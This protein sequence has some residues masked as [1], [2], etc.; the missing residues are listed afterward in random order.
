VGDADVLCQSTFYSDLF[1]A[2]MYFLK[3]QHS[4]LE[5]ANERAHKFF[6]TYGLEH[7]NTSEK[8][9][10]TCLQRP[11]LSVLSSLFTANLTQSDVRLTKDEF[12][13]AARQYVCLPP[14]KNNAGEIVDRKCG[15]EVQ[16]CANS[17]CQKKD[18]E[19]DG[20]GNHARVC[21]PG[22]KALKATILEKALE[23]S[24]R[25]AGGT[26][27]RQPSIY[28]LLGGYFSKEDLSVLFPGK[29]TK[30]QSE[31]RKKLA[32]TYLD[33]ISKVPRG[34]MRNAELDQLR[35]RFPPPVEEKDD[36]NGVIRFD[37]KFPTSNPMDCP[38]ELWFD[39]AIVHETSPTY[40][41]DTLRF[42]EAK[43]TNL[44]ENGPAFQKIVGSKRRRY[45]ALITVVQQLAKDRKLNFQPTFLFP[46]ISS[47][48]FMNEDM[49]EL[50]K[51]IIAR[52]KD[53]Q[54]SEPRRMD[55]MCPKILKGR[56]RVELR[57]SLCF[58]LVKGNAL[59]MSNQ[60]V[61]G[62]TRPG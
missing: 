55:G 52:F 61:R 20:A 30:R 28:T 46:V 50:Q 48:G 36:G 49:I 2:E 43:I 9:L 40:A 47:L 19:L 13:I 15:C 3:L 1:K 23:T 8:I 62:V 5:V 26:P 39:H 18:A 29:L 45:G 24:F 7:A 14:L 51:F 38:R 37:L 32:I 4:F 31:E 57:N 53:T 60:G 27:A 56:F 41:E 59:A 42:L 17:S 35:E 21:H 54:K 12:T 33:I 58:A 22:V 10:L 11:G 16:L 44:P 25:R 34:H 6:L